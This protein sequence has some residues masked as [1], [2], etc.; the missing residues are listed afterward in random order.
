VVLVYVDDLII[1]G[2]DHAVILAFKTYLRTCFHMN[3][4]GILKYFLGVEVARSPTGILL[5]QR[6]YALDIISEAGLLESKPAPTPL[7]QNHHLALANGRILDQP[8]KYRRLVGRLIYLCFTRP[9]L[10]YCVHILSQFMQQPK[11]EHWEAALRVVRY[12]KG[13][14]GQGI[15]LWHDSPLQLNGWCDSDW[16]SCPFDTTITHKMVY[17]S[18]SLTHILEN[19]ETTYCFTIFH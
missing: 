6:K 18:R 16:A 15:L 3:D 14:H 9:E 1:S 12:L 5:C 2:N 10:S 13:N 8:N 17:Y 7:E 19:Q 4:L 11:Q